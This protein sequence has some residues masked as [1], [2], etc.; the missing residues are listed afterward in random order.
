MS[1]LDMDGKAR[2]A[3]L[4]AIRRA[5]ET[6]ESVSRN[7]A[8]DENS[9]K[10]YGTKVVENDFKKFAVDEETRKKISTDDGVHCVEPMHLDLQ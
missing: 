1:I 3:L 5:D 10:G 6:I 2:T 7:K 4:I 9:E 8:E